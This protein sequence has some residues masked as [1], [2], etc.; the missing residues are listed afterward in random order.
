L[1]ARLA[2]A[3]VGGPGPRQQR[4]PYTT[5]DVRY[6]A[7]HYPHSTAQACAAALG[8]TTGSLRFF[9]HQQPELRKQGRP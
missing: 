6:L 9:L 3:P 8:R 7:Q 4:R 2:A 5:A 1:T